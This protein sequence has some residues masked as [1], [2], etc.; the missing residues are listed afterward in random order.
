MIVADTDVLI[1]YLSDR[2]AAAAVQ[3]LLNQGTIATTVVNQ[4][5]LLSG[6]KHSAYLERVQKLLRAMPVLPLDAPAAERAS[7][8]NKSPEGAGNKISMADSLIAGIVSTRGEVLFT[9]NRRHFERIP[10]LRLA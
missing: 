7:E 1:D 9:R 5:E 8:I 4:F 6:A 3:D 10:G 2:G